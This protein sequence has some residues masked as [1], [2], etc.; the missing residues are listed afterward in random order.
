K[1]PVMMP[2]PAVIGL[3]TTGFEMMVRSTAIAIW[4]VGGGWFTAAVVAA[5]NLLD[6]S[7]SRV[8]ATAHCVIGSVWVPPVSCAEAFVMLLP[9]ITTG[10]RCIFESGADPA[11]LDRYQT[12]F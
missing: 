10:P 9:M 3:W 2:L 6:P 12:S 8:N 11:A 1:F 4:L 5:A 7:L